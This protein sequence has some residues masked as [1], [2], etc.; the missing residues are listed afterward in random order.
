LWQQHWGVLLLLPLLVG[1]LPALALP[2][3]LLPV[4]LLG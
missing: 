3:P 1:L 4:L 2:Q